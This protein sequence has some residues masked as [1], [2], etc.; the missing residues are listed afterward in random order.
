T[1]KKVEIEQKQKFIELLRKMK[2]TGRMTIRMA[3]LKVLKGSEY[4]FD[5]EDGDT[6]NIPEKNSVVNVA[7]AVMTQGSHL[8]SN[9]MCYED[10]IEATGGYSRYADKN[11]VFVIKVDG[12][13]RK[14]SKK[15][16]TWN[17]FRSRWEMTAFGGE[18]RQI[19]P[20]DCIVVP[21]KIERIAWL[22]EIRDI[23]Q[24]LMNIAVTAG[25]A[26]NLY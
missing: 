1:A 18:I 24:L 16:I 22:R 23:T 26:V 9:K 6:L 19:E 21:E 2:A 4:D 10:Y 15:F 25:V 13:A 17:P 12:S 20:G 5:L 7:G 11:N 3:D 8:Y 14:I